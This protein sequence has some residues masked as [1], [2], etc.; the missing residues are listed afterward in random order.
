MS[1]LLNPGT[2]PHQP[3]Q[4]VLD[5][6]SPWLLLKGNRK[7]Y[8]D[9]YVKLFKVSTEDIAHAYFSQ[10]MDGFVDVNMMASV[11]TIARHTS[12]KNI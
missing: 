8:G 3:V 6:S 1:H 5:V 10:A 7:I 2:L 11:E 4:S 9:D 12:N